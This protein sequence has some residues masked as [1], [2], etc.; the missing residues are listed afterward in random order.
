MCSPH[1]LTRH[2]AQDTFRAYMRGSTRGGQS[3]QHPQRTRAPLLS[4]SRVVLSRQGKTRPCPSVQGSTQR[5]SR[6]Y[7]EGNKWGQHAGAT[8][9]QRTHIQGLHTR[10][11]ARGAEGT[12][13]SANSR[14][15]ALDCASCVELSGK[16]TAE[17]LCVDYGQ[18]VVTEGVHRGQQVGP[19]RGGSKRG[20]RTLSRR[21]THG[22]TGGKRT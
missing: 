21:S 15:L 13:P 1:K 17:A 20:Q 14:A 3:G 5:W 11:H 22:T 6:V 16:D 12:A 7:T 4:I 9:H 2:R 19:A 10:Q 8:H 18:S